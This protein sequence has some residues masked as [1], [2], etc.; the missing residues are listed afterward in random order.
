MSSEISRND[1]CFS[2]LNIHVSL[3]L[4][5]YKSNKYLHVVD[6]KAVYFSFIFLVV[7]SLF[8]CMSLC[9]LVCTEYFISVYIAFI[10]INVQRLRGIS[11]KFNRTFMFHGIVSSKQLVYIFTIQEND[12][13][14]YHC[15][16]FLKILCSIFLSAL[17]Q[18]MLYTNTP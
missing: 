15:V 5:S 2:I 4:Y 16:I 11:W 9:V 8:T 12:V 13:I 17:K 14:M 18:I 3:L 7:F 1:T 6:Y 10:F